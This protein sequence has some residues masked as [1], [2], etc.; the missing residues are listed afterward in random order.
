MNDFATRLPA[1]L[2]RQARFERL[3]PSG[4]PALLAHPDWERPA[5]LVL[6]MHGRTVSKELDNGRYLRWIRAGIAACAIDLPGH[7]ER[8]DEAWQTPERTPDLIAQGLREVDE[9]IEALSDR[10]FEGVI[11][12]GRLAIG[13]MSAGG[14]V[15]LRRLCETN[16]PHPFVCGAVEATAGNLGM[17][18]GHVPAGGAAAPGRV[19]HSAERIAPVDPMRHIEGWRHIGL[20]ALHSRADEVVPV[21][22]I[23]SFVEAL[24]ARARARGENPAEIELRTWE[25]TGAPHE[26]NGFGLLANEAKNI[27]LEFLTRWLRPGPVR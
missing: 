22:C 11:D 1:A 12:L 2:Q 16:P 24:R 6:W 17:L 20:L 8:R 7:G 4:V 23:E 9:V 15:A 21:A 14:M 3:G 26:H 13:G 25:R 5:P 10:R 18:Y 27:Q 19:R